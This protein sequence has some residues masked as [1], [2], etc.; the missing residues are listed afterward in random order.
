MH[1]DVDSIFRKPLDSGGKRN[2]GGDSAAGEEDLSI[3]A[4]EVRVQAFILGGRVAVDDHG[5]PVVAHLGFWCTGGIVA[6]ADDFGLVSVDTCCVRQFTN[7]VMA[8]ACKPLA[9]AYR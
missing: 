2:Q 6:I 8:Y 4:G 3:L 9:E 1:R 7:G 5:V